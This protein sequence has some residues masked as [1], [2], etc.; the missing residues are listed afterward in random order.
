MK[1]IFKAGLDLLFPPSCPY[2][3]K[4]LAN[5][6]SNLCGECFSRLKFIQTPYC[7]CCGRGF[8]GNGE[9]HLC[10]DCLQSSW[11]FDKAR[12]LFAYGEV[13]AGLIHNLKYSGKTT[14]IATVG[15]LSRQSGVVHDLDD[16]DFILP[17]PL[18]IKRL[19]QRGFNQANMLAKAI[20]SDE[21]KKYVPTSSFVRQTHPPKLVSVDESGGKT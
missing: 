19:R 3:K 4:M 1:K 16:S 9:N 8:L 7:T 18:H 21:R 15:W 10:G 11:A 6:D 13:V 2:C 14:G 20:F 12:S 5:S 17:V